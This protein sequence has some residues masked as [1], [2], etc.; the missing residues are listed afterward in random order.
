MSHSLSYRSLQVL[1]TSIL[2]LLMVSCASSTPK[3]TAQEWESYRKEKLNVY[4][5]NRVGI[6]FDKVAG[7][8]AGTKSARYLNLSPDFLMIASINGQ[9]F[10]FVDL[11]KIELIYKDRAQHLSVVTKT[12]EIFADRMSDPYKYNTNFFTGFEFTDRDGRK[13]NDSREYVI[14]I[15]DGETRKAN[16]FNMESKFYEASI[17]STADVNKYIAN[18]EAQQEKQNTEYR[19]RA[20]KSSAMADAKIKAN[21]EATAR[22]RKNIAIGTRTN[23]GIV[24][25]LRRPLALLQLQNGIRVFYRIDDLSIPEVPSACTPAN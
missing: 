16:F 7:N 1:V 18:I 21:D 12:G 14:A 4:E 8:F 9:R 23:C 3:K 25:E 15:V 11:K 10:N 6:N 2:V 5:D 24:V 20:K 13:L 19:E 17:I 22:M